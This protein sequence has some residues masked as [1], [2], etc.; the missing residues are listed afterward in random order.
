MQN[1]I[2]W[3]YAVASVCL[4]ALSG[5]GG[6]PGPVD[7][8]P[9]PPEEAA[10]VAT[11]V[12]SPDAALPEASAE[13][14]AKCEI[15]LKDKGARDGFISVEMASD[16]YIYSY[17]RCKVCGFYALETYIDRASGS[18]D[19]TVDA[20]IT[21]AEGDAIIEAIKRC[22]DVRDEGCACDTHKSLRG[23]K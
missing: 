15:D 3:T 4:L 17:W 16:E 12:A 18:E 7:P 10:P 14:C 5:C 11:P 8:A 23:D 21:P 1:V 19:I 20:A 6:S 2:R 9:M 22:P 13:Q